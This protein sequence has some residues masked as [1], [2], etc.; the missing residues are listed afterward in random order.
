MKIAAV[1][2]TR[3]DSFRLKFWKQYYEE[4]K[5]EL[6]EHIV[7]DN[8]SSP[9]YLEEL[10]SAFPESTIIELG[11]NGGCTGAYNAGIKHALSHPEVD[12]ILLVGND[13]RIERGGISKLYELLFSSV[14]YGM[15][16]PVLLKK[17]SEIVESFGSNLNLKNGIAKGLY[18][19]V[20]FNTIANKVM[21]VSFVPGGANL[22]KRTFYES[23]GVGLQD[24]N[25]FMYCDER[26]MG[27]RAMQKGIKEIAT[28]HVKSWHQHIEK[29][30]N[31]RDPRSEYLRARNYIYVSKKFF[32]RTTLFRELIY[33]LSL[34][35]VLFI[36]DFRDKERR[37]QFYYYLK[38]MKAGITNNMDNS[39]MNR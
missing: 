36:R 2:L 12:A 10:K 35:S 4:Y 22:S 20:P 5:D 14:D 7:V 26:D 9:E 1:S 21:E 3:N 39:I 24:E 33:R 29:K 6:Y 17:D 38:G 30:G 13:V 16:G 27:L 31:H 28:S 34:Q 25:L 37:Q 18:H 15:V 11:Y 8:G 32:P 23:S 19:N